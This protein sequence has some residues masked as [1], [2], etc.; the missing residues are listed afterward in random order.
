MFRVGALHVDLHPLNF[1]PLHQPLYVAVA[2]GTGG[3]QHKLLQ[4]YPVNTAQNS[5]ISG[6]FNIGTSE[7]ESSCMDEMLL[8]FKLMWVTFFNPIKAFLLIDLIRLPDKLNLI[9]S[10]RPR[11]RTFPSSIVHQ[12]SL[13]CKSLQVELIVNRLWNKI[14]MTNIYFCICMMSY[15]SQFWI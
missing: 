3:V 4:F 13:L 5:K 6:T 8:W 11:N 14:I 15:T 12:T 7:K 1:D 9:K 10:L 2:D